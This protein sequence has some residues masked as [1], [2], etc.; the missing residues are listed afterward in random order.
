L[1]DRIG[2]RAIEEVALGARRVIKSDT[3]LNEW[4]KIPHA[5]QKAQ[6]PFWAKGGKK[7]EFWAMKEKVF[8]RSRLAVFAIKF[9][10]TGLLL[11]L[12]FLLTS[13]IEYPA[14]RSGA[15]KNDIINEEANWNMKDQAKR[16][17]LTTEHYVRDIVNHPAFK[18]FGELMLPQDDNTYH[19]DTRLKQVG[20]LMPYHNHVNPDI[21]VAALN[22]LIDEVNAG[23]I[24]F[25]DFYTEGQKQED[26]TKKPTGLFFYRGKPGAPFAIV[27]PGGGFSYVGSLHEG[28]PLAWAISQKGLNAFVIRY[29]IAGEQKAT[30][31]LAAAIAY[32]FRNAQTL[33]VNT[34]GYSLWGGSAGARMV[35]NI[36]LSGVSRYGG[37]NL[38]KPSTVVIAYTGQS[39]YSGN[40]PPTFIT[41]SANDGIANVSTVERRVENL[42]NTGVEVEYRR[43]RNAGHGFGLG[44]GTDAEGWITYA[45]QFWEKH[46]SK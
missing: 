8:S 30:E 25:Y 44:V 20:S 15:D 10:G 28:F 45:I 38:H 5:I 32:I 27:C 34:Q 29:R 14:V 42:R 13:C 22:H 17:H 3:K 46:L 33:G 36:A 12:M 40:F 4:P 19:Y 31:D 24:S 23:K 26:P 16:G 43:Y 41:V 1:N 35:G 11:L 2:K 9:G 18:G 21:V 6:R 39:S 37:G 7:R